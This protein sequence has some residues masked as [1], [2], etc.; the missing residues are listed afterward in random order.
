M[1]KLNDVRVHMGHWKLKSIW[2]KDLSLMGRDW[3]REEHV[4]MGSFPV[5][6]PFCCWDAV[7]FGPANLV[8]VHIINWGSHTFLVERQQSTTPPP[9]ASSHSQWQARRSRFASCPLMPWSPNLALH[10]APEH[11]ALLRS[12]FL[13]ALLLQV[14]TSAR[15]CEAQV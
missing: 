9:C 8:T 6:V 3:V 12:L 7:C 5:F 2:P 14:L 15:F 4:S 11:S 1:T 10:S 13:P